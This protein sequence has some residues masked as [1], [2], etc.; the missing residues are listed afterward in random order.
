MEF[1]FFTTVGAMIEVTAIPARCCG[2]AIVAE[3]RI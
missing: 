2:V 3:S 1:S